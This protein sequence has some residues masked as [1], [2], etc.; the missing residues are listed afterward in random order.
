MPWPCGGA[1][2]VCSGT[3]TDS[4][5]GDVVTTDYGLTF[6]AFGYPAASPDDGEELWRCSGVAG[7]DTRGTTDHRLPCSMTGGSSGG[8]WI[9]GGVLN[10]VNSF[11]YQGER[12]VMYGPYFGSTAQQVYN[13]AQND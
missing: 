5:N 13:A 12:D 11:G 9:T 6:D 10:S 3:A 2:Y 4:A 1:N 7:Q 8:G